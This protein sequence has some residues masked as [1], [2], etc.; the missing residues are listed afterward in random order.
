M[1]LG[2]T[3]SEPFPIKKKKKN[4]TYTGFDDQNEVKESESGRKYEEYPLDVSSRY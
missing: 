3:G 1:K 4:K 2:C